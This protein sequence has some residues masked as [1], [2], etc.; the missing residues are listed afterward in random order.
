VCDKD[1]LRLLER[2]GFTLDSSAPAFR[3]ALPLP[4]RRGS[5]RRVPVSAGPRPRI[6]RR[7]GLPTWARF[8]LL[9]LPTLIHYPEERLLGL[10]DEIL[11]VQDRAGAP[12]HLVAFA[13]PWEFADLPAAGASPAH[14]ARLIARVELLA[15][16]LPLRM[17][18]VEEIA[19]EAL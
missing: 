11:A 10:V 16:H 18:T 12:R 17:C 5:L 19:A 1:T 3:G 9:N 7:L 15:R 4:E 13:H 2:S 8:E 14:R 6:R